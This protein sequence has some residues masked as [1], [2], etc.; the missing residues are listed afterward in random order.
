MGSN[1]DRTP[2]MPF[3]RRP[4][5]VHPMRLEG[6]GLRATLAAFST[7]RRWHAVA[8][9]A[10]LTLLMTGAAALVPAQRETVIAKCELLQSASS[11]ALAKGSAEDLSA[12][13]THIFHD[14]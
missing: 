14:T 11:P 2:A 9:L 13:G 10:V 6:E 5:L 4:V 12:L 7:F 1:G 3:A 8:G